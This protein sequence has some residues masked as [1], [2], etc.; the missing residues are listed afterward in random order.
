MGSR[1][2]LE[3]EPCTVLGHYKS[4]N[5]LAANNMKVAHK[6]PWLS[7]LLLLAAYTMF[8]SFLSTVSVPWIVWAIAI[9]WVFLLA[10]FFMAPLERIR[11]MLGRWLKTDSMAFVS[12]VIAAFLASFVVLWWNV[13]LYVLAI[14]AAEALARLD[15]QTNQFTQSNAFFIL[16][17]TSLLGIGFGWATHQ[18][19][20]MMG[21]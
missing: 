10:V 7:L 18:W 21:L 8:G 1:S 2:I 17:T 14:V 11:N 16:M 20:L 15:I 4:S 9:T 3:V 19:S 6:F 12:L 13:F 5:T